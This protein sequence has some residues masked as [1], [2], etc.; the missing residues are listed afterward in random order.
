MQQHL[1]VILVIHLTIRRRILPFHLFIF[2]F[3]GNMI[4]KVKETCKFETDLDK[5]RSNSRLHK[6]KLRV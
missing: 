1:A 4:S 2:F 6:G 5:N 3:L